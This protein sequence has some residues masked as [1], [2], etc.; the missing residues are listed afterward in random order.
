MYESAKFS[1]RAWGWSECSPRRRLRGCVLPTC[2]GM[3]RAPRT[4]LEYVARSP[5][6][7][8][9]GPSCLISSSPLRSFSHVRG[10]GPTDDLVIWS[11]VGFSPRAW[12]WSVETAS[13]SLASQR[14]P[15][16]RGDGPAAPGS[17]QEQG[18]FSP[19]AWG[20]SGPR[21]ERRG[22]AQVLPTC[23]GMV[24]RSAGPTTTR[25]YIVPGTP[26]LTP[27]IKYGVPR[28]AMRLRCLG[29]G[30]S[31]RR[32][33]SGATLPRQAPL[34]SRPGVQGQV[35]ESWL[36]VFAVQV[37]AD[38]GWDVDVLE[39][40]AADLC[41]DPGAHHVVPVVEHRL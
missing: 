29:C 27:K 19:R 36:P 15:H 20:W 40:H 11:H 35:E 4:S 34:L 3:V 13:S 30:G 25:M 38:L 6:V 8:G 41:E 9:D 39:R 7:R 14:S 26:Y 2:V 10:D 22:L 31:C 1:P 37:G 16:V 24:R 28:T 5:H 18:L 33:R 32:S 12:G 23:V 17:E 21:I